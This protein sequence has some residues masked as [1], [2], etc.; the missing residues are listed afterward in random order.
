VTFHDQDGRQADGHS[1]SRVKDTFAA[2]MGREEAV[3]IQR[4]N[5]GHIHKMFVLDEADSCQGITEG[6]SVG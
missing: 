1:L 5:T 2:V 6:Q 4:G 3:N